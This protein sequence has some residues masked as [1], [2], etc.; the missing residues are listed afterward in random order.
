[1]NVCLIKNNVFT[2]TQLLQIPVSTDRICAKLPAAVGWATLWSEVWR[3]RRGPAFTGVVLGAGVG[4]LGA[5]SGKDDCLVFCCSF[6]SACSLSLCWRRY[7]ALCWSCSCC[8]TDNSCRETQ[9]KLN[10][11]I[12]TAITAALL[13]PKLL[14]Q[15]ICTFDL[16]QTFTPPDTILTFIQAWDCY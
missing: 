1:M 12:S 16:A 3:R 6:R 14:P 11:Y 9:V 15:Y 4:L 10:Y 5:S 2:S 7:A 13:S 8:D